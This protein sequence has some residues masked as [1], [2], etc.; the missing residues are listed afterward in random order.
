LNAAKIHK[1]YFQ[2]YADLTD[3]EKEDLVERHKENREQPV[4][5]RATPRARAQ[6]FANVV[7]NMAQLVSSF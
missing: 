7:H 6:D 2:E 4:V 5:R 1:Q 3:K